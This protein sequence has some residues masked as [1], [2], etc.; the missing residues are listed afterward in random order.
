MNQIN[1][2]NN[3]NSNIN[4]NAK[5]NKNKPA[6]LR[7]LIV[8]DEQQILDSLQFLLRKRYKISVANSGEAAWQKM[9]GGYEPQLVISDARMPNMQGHQL[10]A[11]IHARFPNVVCIM[12][13]GYVD[14]ESLIQAINEGHIYN[15][16]VKPWLNESLLL[17]IQKAAE[18]YCLQ[19]SNI[20][21]AEELKVINRSLEEKVE[22]RTKELEQRNL[23]LDLAREH[24]EKMT[25]AKSDFLANISHEV[26]TP[27]NGIVVGAGL[28][29]NTELTEEQENYLSSIQRSSH[30]MLSLVSNI[31][32]FSKLEVNLM[33]LDVRP[34]DIHRV[35][36][37]MYSFYR[38]EASKR[39][40]ELT[41]TI[42][43]E[44]P[45]ILRGDQYRVKQIFSNLISN[46]I[47]HTLSGSVAVELT[48]LSTVA[49]PQKSLSAPRYQFTVTDSGCGI[50]PEA[51]VTLF[52]QYRQGR[53]TG[54]Q[55]TKGTGLGLAIAKQLSE[56]MNGSIRVESEVD[57]G[58]VF[59]V[60]FEQH[61]FSSQDQTFA[62]EGVEEDIWFHNKLACGMAEYLP[63]RILVA[64]DNNINSVLLL[65]L[66]EKLG[67]TATAVTNGLEVL[68]AVED[69][70]FDIILMDINMPKMSG[71]EATEKIVETYPKDKRPRI[72]A[73]SASSL[74]EDIDAC[75]Q[76]GVEDYLCKPIQ[77]DDIQ[78]VLKKGRDISR[79][80]A[81]LSKFN[82]KDKKGIVNSDFLRQYSE[83]TVIKI[84]EI[85]CQDMTT[86][87]A[88]L[89]LVV[90]Q[91]QSE[92]IF[93]VCHSSKGVCLNLGAELLASK[94]ERILGLL[95]K[96]DFGQIES[97]LPNLVS[98]FNSTKAELNRVMAKQPFKG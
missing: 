11:K 62:S 32:D 85:F 84:A 94:L 79:Y 74:K 64:E 39:Y 40:T 30:E 38:L 14:I 23:E 34:Y 36:K 56:L 22:L 35:L 13:T 12:L 57:K 68:E 63:L 16:V 91:R 5:D 50:E 96:E 28:L 21:L 41:L 8:D 60:E 69:N 9:V 31:L 80:Q 20:E 10:L 1:A 83:N 49:T 58:S 4:S 66:L 72:I 61:R 86:M 92:K 43:P 7:L 78:K 45:Q 2:N 77:L 42:D 71:L 18:Y 55:S 17:T 97:S 15:Y 89:P 6:L 46:A 87:L 95:K 73:L 29:D 47:H 19:V 65:M 53:S 37:E 25:R 24:A 27:L 98:C 70:T 48:V 75:Y 81:S 67:Y 59:T 90:K 82:E 3:A 33:V 52:E 54:V 44:V 93:D 51:L 88:R 26:R 76:A